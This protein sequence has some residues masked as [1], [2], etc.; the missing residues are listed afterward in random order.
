[1]LDEALEAI[2]EF[3]CEVEG[4]SA[5]ALDVEGGMVA[6]GSDSGVEG[7]DVTELP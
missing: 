5:V 7:I 1:M 2:A 6:V 3:T 4:V